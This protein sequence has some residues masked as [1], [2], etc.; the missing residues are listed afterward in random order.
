MKVYLSDLAILLPS[1]GVSLALIFVLIADRLGRRLVPRS[2]ISLAAVSL[3]LAAITQVHMI[4]YMLGAEMPALAIL[5]LFPLLALPV[6]ALVSVVRERR[7]AI[8]GS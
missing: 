5:F 2:K 1:L 3:L 7:R 8:S 4:R 6:F